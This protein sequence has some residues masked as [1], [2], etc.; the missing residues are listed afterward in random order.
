MNEN[1]GLRLWK[2][3]V[4]LLVLCNIALVLTIWVKPTLHGARPETPRDFVI[5]SLRFSDDQ[6][7]KYDALISVHSNMM[8]SL[9]KESMT[10]RQQLFNNLKNADNPGINTDSL[11]QLIANNQKQIERGTYDHFA[12]VRTICTNE[13]KAD[14]DKIIMDVIRK[15]MPGRPKGK[16]GDGHQP[17]NDRPGPPENE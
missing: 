7:K 11:A 3:A 14:F 10:Y 5:R 4:V 16:N 6:V 8:D 1:K 9:R 17:P 13:Q 12:Q 15:M 2:F